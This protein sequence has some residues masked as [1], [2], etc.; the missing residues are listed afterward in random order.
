MHLDNRRWRVFVLAAV[1]SAGGMVQRSSAAGPDAAGIEFFEKKIRPV[2]VAHCY[3]CH[4]AEAAK[5]KKLRGG[6]LLDSRDGLLKG[7]DSG[8]SLVP[9][10]PTASL[11]IKAVQHD[12]LKMPPKGMLPAPVI[13]DLAKWVEM[14]APDPRDGSPLIAKRAIDLEAGRKHW[15]FKPLTTVVPP[16][17][18]DQPWVRTSIDRFI[19]AKLSEK[20]LSPN[21]VINQEKLIRRVYFDLTGLPP[22]PPDIE[23]FLKDTGPDAYGRLIDRLLSSERYGERWARHWLDVVRFAES[24]GYEFDGDRP[25][26]FYYRDFVIRAL[27]RD[28]PFDEFVRLQIAGDHL[29]PGEL[30]A[31]AATGFLV[32]GPYP[33][34]TTAKTLEPIRYDHLDDMISTL[35]TSLLGLSLGCARCHE[36]KYDPIPQSD[37]Y[38]LIACLARTD[39]ARTAIEIERETYAAAKVAFEQAHAPLVAARDKF[40]KEELPGRLQKWFAANKDVTAPKWL[41]LDAGSAG[42]ATEALRRLD[43]VSFVVRNP[44]KNGPDSYTFTAQTHHKGVVAFRLEALP[45]PSLP[46]QG[47][48]RGPQGEFVVNE[49]AVTA[50]PLDAETKK[51]KAT[52]VKLKPVAVRP[53]GG[54]LTLSVDGNPKTGWA[55]GGKGMTQSAVFAIEQP[56]GHDGGTALTF[57]LTFAPGKGLGRFRFAVST[58]ANAAPDALA[59][60]QNASELRILLQAQAG[61]PISNQ[62]PMAVRWYRAMDPTANQVHATVEEH[63]KKEPKPRTVDVFAATS[64]KGGDVHYLIRGETSR[65]NG[66]ARPGFV[67]VLVDASQ[68]ADRW[69]APTAAGQVTKP[70][71][72]APRLALARWLTDTEAGA[73]RLLARV[74]VNRL[75]Q[76]HLGNG[77]VRTPNDFG[78]QGEPPTHPELLDWLANELIRSGWSLKTI[79]KLILTSAVYMQDCTI[80]PEAV[81]ADPDNRLW[82]RRAPRRLEAEA[83]R[84][85]LLS[86][87]GTLDLT[88]YGPGTLEEASPRRSVYLTVKRSRLLPMLQTFDA[89]EPIQG[90]GARQK[91]TAATQALAMM[92]SPLVRQQADR[93]AQRVRPKSAA[94]LPAAIGQAYRHALGRAPSVAET[95]RATRFVLQQGDK[96][97][98]AALAD[99]CQVLLCSN[100]FLYVD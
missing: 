31:T 90:I 96:G 94:G 69:L 5:A 57:T 61:K 53:E 34:Q 48:G 97:R 3:Q 85:T 45:D 8:P 15:A 10:K 72:V 58:S 65:K 56:L 17:V 77:I 81:K 23:D 76:H 49:I 4:S 42:P 47:P 99:F 71:P 92:N 44:K 21:L 68:G 32:A 80:N 6:L 25:G 63:A 7:G 83:L 22:A 98:D 67:Q 79:H 50:A 64:N 40:V 9:G 12:S 73:G 13:A 54:D 29:Y 84:D 26:A 66:L 91:T 100:E 46:N 60:L 43:D 27:N 59:D 95:E 35:G 18:P 2:L 33:G 36:H 1:L 88:M 86:I 14:G 70:T 74:I 39:S 89:P 20:R 87:G 55:A 78:A 41:L 16:P 11:L 75:W 28:L 93:L 38:H 82:W 52:P 24:G 37:Y 51:I 30:D 62:L 19:L